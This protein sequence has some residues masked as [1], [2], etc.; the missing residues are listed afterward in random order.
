MFKLILILL[1]LFI[2]NNLL[3]SDFKICNTLSDC[4]YDEICVSY[5]GCKNKQVHRCIP[6]SCYRSGVNCPSDLVCTNKHCSEL[7]C[8]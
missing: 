1:I 3:S 4:Q 5:T 8:K 7:G 6:R 2:N